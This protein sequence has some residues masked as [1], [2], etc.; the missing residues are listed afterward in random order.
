MKRN[1]EEKLLAVRTNGGFENIRSSQPLEIDTSMPNEESECEA[2]SKL[3]AYTPFKTS[4][5]KI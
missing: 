3:D 5:E 2:R 1:Y 4:W